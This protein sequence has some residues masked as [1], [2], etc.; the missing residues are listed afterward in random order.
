MAAFANCEGG[1][2]FV[3]VRDDG[4]I[5]GVTDPD[6]VIRDVANLARDA[7]RPALRP[8]IRRVT[9]AQGTLVAICVPRQILPRQVDGKH[10]L[11]VGTTVREATSEEIAAL[12]TNRP[13]L[14]DLARIFDAQFAN[15]SPRNIQRQGPD[16]LAAATP[17]DEWQ[18][19]EDMRVKLYQDSEGLFL[20]HRWKPSSVPGQV[21]DIAISIAQHKAGPLTRGEIT[22]VEYQL[23]PRFF[24]DRVII[25]DASTQFRLD[26][27]AYAPM[28]CLAKVT[29]STGRPPLYVWRYIDFDDGRAPNNSLEPTQPGPR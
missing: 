2:I 3:G 11:R 15:F 6:G 16:E 12:Y 4:D 18:S 29:F 25:T 26:V 24:R 10:Y 28:L 21:A 7:L 13:E 22:S 8:E 17:P 14:T 27:S 5:C 23:G 20:V 9:A 19:L 1:V